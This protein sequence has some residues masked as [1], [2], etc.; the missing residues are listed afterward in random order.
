M[1]IALTE[2]GQQRR[3]GAVI[4]M[5]PVTLLLEEKLAFGSVLQIRMDCSLHSNVTVAWLNRHPHAVGPVPSRLSTSPMQH[6]L[7]IVPTMTLTVRRLWCD[8]DSSHG[9][10]TASIN[11]G[12]WLQL[13]SIGDILGWR[14]SGATARVSVSGGVVNGFSLRRQALAT[15]HSRRLQ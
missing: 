9:V 12:R 14:G 5:P 10:R 4:H 1:L 3:G 7:Y 11:S 15:H 13:R 2:P 6:E 8:R